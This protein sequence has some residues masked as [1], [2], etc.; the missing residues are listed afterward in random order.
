MKRILTLSIT[1]SLISLHAICKPIRIDGIYYNLSA[2][3]HTASVS[4][5]N[6][7]SAYGGGTYSGDVVIPS[8]ISYKGTSYIVTT[9]DEWAFSDCPKLSSVILPDSLKRINRFAFC[10]S[11]N[12][13]SIILPDSVYLIGEGA[14]IWSGLTSISL[15]S[16]LKY[17][18]NSAF[19]GCKNLKS[20]VIP[21]NAIQ[22]L[23]KI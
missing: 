6:P 11:K 12:L 21:E 22:T 9:I 13:K 8:I 7:Y 17:I 3:D 14:F 19:K 23:S 4:C 15:P 2:E 5:P 20:I 1:L 18:D 16:H 10:R